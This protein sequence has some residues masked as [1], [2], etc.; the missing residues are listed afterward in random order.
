MTP[1]KN[2]AIEPDLL[3]RME[4]AAAAEGKTVDDLANEAAKRYMAL[5]RLDRLQTYGQKRADD[6]GITE[7]DIPRLISESRSERHR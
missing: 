6:L 1:K 7:N 4:E 2:V 3:G 5:R